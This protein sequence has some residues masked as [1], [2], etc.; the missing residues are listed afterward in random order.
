MIYTFKVSLDK[1][2]YRIIEIRGNKTLLD[3]ATIILKSYNFDMD[4]MFGFY[5]NLKN[6]Y[7]SDEAYELLD[8]SGFAVN[9]NTK[10]LSK[11]S[12]E[13][14]FS[15]KKKMLFL[16]DYGDEWYFLIEC[17]KINDAEHKKR[18]PRVIEKIGKAPEQYPDYE[19]E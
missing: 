14:V 5:S 9:N 16:F 18:Y 13:E 6:P 4:H 12:I 15:L 19:E 11:T 17:K 3:L 1:D 2:L 8:E 10:D 7:K